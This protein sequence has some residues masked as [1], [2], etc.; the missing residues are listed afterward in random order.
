MYLSRDMVTKIRAPTRAALWTL[1]KKTWPLALSALLV[2]LYMRIDVVLLNFWYGAHASG[3]YAVAV[4]I[5][6]TGFIIPTSIAIAAQPAILRGMQV[7]PDGYKLRLTRLFRLLHLVGFAQGVVLCFAAEW[8]VRI[9][10]GP[11][12]GHA[13]DVLRILAWAPWFVGLGI[14]RSIHLIGIH[15]QTAHLITVLIGACS[16]IIVAWAAIPHLGA[17]GAACATLVAYGMAALGSCWCIPRL[18]PTGAWMLQSLWSNQ[19]P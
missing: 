19:H 14:A 18:R 15:D 6:E 8:I 4:R 2:T 1:F 13:A 17:V 10:F 16:G 11:A 3:E 7:D 9:L 5:A 12:F